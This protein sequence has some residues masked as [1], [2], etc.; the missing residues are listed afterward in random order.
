MVWNNDRL[1]SAWRWAAQAHAGQTITG[2][3]L[4]YLT[5]LG[6]VTLELAAALAMPNPGLADPELALL[7]AVLHDIIE[8]TEAT[9]AQVQERFGTAV[10]EGV[11]ALTKDAT[12][13]KAEQMADSLRRIQRQPPEVWC[14]KLA[15]RISNLMPPPNHWTPEKIAAYR[16]EAVLIH[17]T[18]GSANPW[19]ADRLWAKI[20]SY[21]ANATT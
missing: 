18:L 13:P 19:L 10:A 20:L 7:C 2:T 14:V 9:Y 8:D 3:A 17:Q 16:E 1:I 12:L 21:P 4:P 6:Q 15:D 5:H 11:L